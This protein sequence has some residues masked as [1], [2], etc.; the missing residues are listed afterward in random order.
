MSDG[1]TVRELLDMFDRAAAYPGIRA[2]IRAVLQPDAATPET[3]TPTAGLREAAQP[4]SQE[5]ALREALFSDLDRR[6]ENAALDAFYKAHILRVYRSPK[7]QAEKLASHDSK[8]SWRPQVRAAVRALG[9]IR[10]EAN[11]PEPTALAATPEPTLAYRQ[12][13]G[14]AA[15]EFMGKL[16][17][18]QRGGMHE[19]SVHEWATPEPA[20]RKAV[21]AWLAEYDSDEGASFAAVDALRA[22]L[23]A[24]PETRQQAELG[25]CP[26]QEAVAKYRR[27]LRVKARALKVPPPNTPGS[28]DFNDGIRA[29]LTLL[30]EPNDD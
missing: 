30:G 12:G 16:C 26:E 6:R 28:M 21:E 7:A 10:L 27:E 18:C 2:A 29:V 23:A 1:L 14:D 11:L 13:M 25:I 17:V 22:A 9:T 24:T 4:R 19:P 8:E 3:P 20:L 15:H 5:A